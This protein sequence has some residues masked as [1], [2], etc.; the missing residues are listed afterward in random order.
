MIFDDLLFLVLCHIVDLMITVE[1]QRKLKLMKTE[2]IEKK[3]EEKVDISISNDEI[4]FL[5]FL[6]FIIFTILATLKVLLLFH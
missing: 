1:H 4:G 6:R 5:N 2:E 3:K